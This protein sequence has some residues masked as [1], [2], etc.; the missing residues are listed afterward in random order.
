MALR[1]RERTGATSRSIACSSVLVCAPVRL[2]KVEETCRSFLP[3]RSIA[4]I[5]FSKVGSAVSSAMRAIST[6]CSAR[7][8]SK[9]G[10]KWDVS[11][12]SK[13]GRPKGVVQ[14]SRRGLGRDASGMVTLLRI[15]CADRSDRGKL[16]E[17]HARASLRRL[18][19][20]PASRHVVWAAQGRAGVSGERLLLRRPP[21]DNFRARAQPDRAA[22]AATGGR[23]AR[24]AHRRPRRA[25]PRAA[26]RLRA[27]RSPARSWRATGGSPQAR[28]S[29]SSKPSPAASARTG[30]SSTP[31]SRPAAARRTTTRPSACTSPPSRA[32]RSSSAA[33]TS[34]PA[35]PRRSSR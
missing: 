32:A 1:C 19:I 7:A 23:A 24:R 33:S 35:A 21:R 6:A 4:A 25:A 29:P 15:V 16:R 27:S 30:P 3:A 14:Q 12:P 5:V 34:P 11:M 22:G 26:A 8:A 20:R 2:K 17:E 28:A 13:G 18:G 31:R 9:A 10:R